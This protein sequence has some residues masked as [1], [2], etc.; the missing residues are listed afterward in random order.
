MWL[1]A[2][3][4]SDNDAVVAIDKISYIAII[5]DAPNSRWLAVAHLVG[6][7]DTLNLTSSTVSAF[8][9]SEQVDR[10]VRATGGLAAI[11]QI[12]SNAGVG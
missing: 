12:T 2:S 10:F 6:S 11:G 4:T 1:G 7:T 5:H 3:D 9:L 8:D